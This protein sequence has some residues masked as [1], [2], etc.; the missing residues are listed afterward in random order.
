MLACPPAEQIARYQRDSYLLP[1]DCP[2]L[3]EVR[4]HR[5][6]RRAFEHEHRDPFGRD[7]C[8]NLDLEPRPAGEFDPASRAVQA[9]QVVRSFDF[10]NLLTVC[11]RS[12]DGEI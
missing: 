5:G 9:A 1:V 12:G 7:E 4:Q 3:D 2:M 10:N 11:R 6:Y 8:G